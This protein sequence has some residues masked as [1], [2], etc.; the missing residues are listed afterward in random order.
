MNLHLC[1]GTVLPLPTQ[2]RSDGGHLETSREHGEVAKRPG[3]ASEGA[4]LGPGSQQRSLMAAVCFWSFSCILT[5]HAER[6]AWRRAFP[7]NVRPLGEVEC[8]FASW[9]ATVLCS[10]VW[11]SGL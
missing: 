1:K 4:V 10:R 8:S 6:A 7:G 5:F 3:T 11:A 2:R 9:G